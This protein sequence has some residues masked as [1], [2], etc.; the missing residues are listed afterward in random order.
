MNAFQK[1][2]LRVGAVLLLGAALAGCATPDESR[3]MGDNTDGLSPGDQPEESAGTSGN[4]TQGDAI[5]PPAMPTT[6][7]GSPMTPGP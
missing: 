7:E 4:N 2:I 6:D 3:D 5:E 1:A